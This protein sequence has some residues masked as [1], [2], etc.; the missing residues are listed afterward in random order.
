[1]KVNIEKYLWMHLLRTKILQTL[2]KKKNGVSSKL[3]L[4]V[5]ISYGIV[6]STKIHALAIASVALVVS[7]SVGALCEFAQLPDVYILLTQNE[8]QVHSSS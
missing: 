3:I 8:E 5:W 6:C 7:I 1:M 2:A 4:N